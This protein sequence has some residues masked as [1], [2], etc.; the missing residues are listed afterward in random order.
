MKLDR[1]GDI[2]FMEAMAGAMTVCLVLT[3]FSAFVAADMLSEEPEEPEFDWNMVGAM[4]IRN[5]NLGLSLHGDF[6]QYL[7][8]N[9]LR[10]IHVHA[11]VPQY[12]NRALDYRVG[13]TTDLCVK[14]SRAI[15]VPDDHGRIYPAMM[16]VTLYQ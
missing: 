14:D 5:G 15:E 11:L 6:R 4:H 1:R 3:A 13:E 8:D 16:E 12:N 10:G 2:G 7:E 9:G